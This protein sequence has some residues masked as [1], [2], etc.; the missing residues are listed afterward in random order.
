[1]CYKIVF[2]S[3]GGGGE[4]MKWHIVCQ[5]GI[6]CSLNNKYVIVLFIY[7]ENMKEDMY[8][9]LCVNYLRRGIIFGKIIAD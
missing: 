8:T 9:K 2:C 7:F 5:L 3:G 4:T 6:Y 1:M